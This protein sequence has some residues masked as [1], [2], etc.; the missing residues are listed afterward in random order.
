MI[1]TQPAFAAPIGTEQVV[2][3]RDPVR[4]FVG[5][6]VR[7]DALADDLTQEIFVRVLRRLPEVR[8]HRRVVGWIFQIARNIVADHFRRSRPA[9][10][11]L[12][13]DGA[14][15]SSHESVG[16]VEEARLRDE[17]TDYVR[18]VVKTLPPIH[19][20]AILL[21]EY[22]GMTQAELARHLGIGLSAAKSRV[23]RARAIVRAR[24]EKCCHVE[25]DAYGTL[26]DCRRRSPAD[27]DCG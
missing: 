16:G 3:F 11:L 2:R 15:E 12:E 7:N 20:E 27:C 5:A 9:T 4:R 17:L 6:R 18:E 25:F 23:Q 22:E 21:T 1:A 19:R 24:V 14:E 13:M 8:D 26:V 10:A